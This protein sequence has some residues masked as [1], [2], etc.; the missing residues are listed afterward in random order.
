MVGGCSGYYGCSGWVGTTDVFNDKKDKKDLFLS[1]NVNYLNNYK[2]GAW[3]VPLVFTTL[4]SVFF[5]TLLSG[6]F[7]CLL[8]FGLLFAF[9]VIWWPDCKSVTTDAFG[10]FLL[11]LLFA[12]G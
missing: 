10:L 6:G 1:N 7:G 2:R 4:L 11:W 3:G 8:A 12:F 5:T 9:W